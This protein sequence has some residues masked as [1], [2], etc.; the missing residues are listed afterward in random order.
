[1]GV[2][3]NSSAGRGKTPSR[4]LPLVHR[5]SINRLYRGLSS[6]PIPHGAFPSVRP[7]TLP[8]GAGRQ[9]AV[10]G[11]SQWNAVPGNA[12]PPREA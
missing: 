9:G 12:K 5:F 8:A 1:M 10:R 4:S 11:D 7:P 6:H 3:Q 2:S